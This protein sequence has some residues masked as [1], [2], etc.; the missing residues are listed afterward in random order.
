[1]LPGDQA[2]EAEDELEALRRGNSG[3]TE[4]IRR[5]TWPSAGRGESKPRNGYGSLSFSGG[6]RNNSPHLF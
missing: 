6:A 1:M 2:S 4:G 5:P 3:C